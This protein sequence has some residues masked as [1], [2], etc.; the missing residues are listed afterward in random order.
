MEYEERV[1][2]CTTTPISRILAA[3]EYTTS[4][5][6]TFDEALGAYLRDGGESRYATVQLRRL[7]RDK[8]LKDIDQTWIDEVAKTLKPTA[9]A[10]TQSR[11]V[12]TLISAVLNDAATRGWCKPLQI[13]R[14]KICKRAP[15]RVPSPEELSRFLGRT[16]PGL[17][18][19]IKFKLDTDAT[20]Y[21]ILS[22]DWTRVS[23]L[24]KRVFLENEKG[25]SRQVSFGS[26]TAEMLARLPH[27]ERHVFRRDDGRPYKLTGSRGGRLK[28][29]LAGA[30]K[31]SGV[32]ISFRTLHYL[33]RSVKCS[34]KSSSD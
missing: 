15:E 28:T 20:E 12:H 9:S 22:L 10:A 4:P 11:Q 21:E 25:S 2:D 24:H 18:K 8:P 26:E 16:G 7:C 27:R 5:T 30:A 29:A 19:I 31:R 34:L 32:R 1:S 17:R 3:K 33:H 23:L 13:H 14:P 6:I